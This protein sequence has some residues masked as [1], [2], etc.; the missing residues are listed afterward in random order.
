MSENSLS[1]LAGSTGYRRKSFEEAWSHAVIGATSG[2]LFTI[3]VSAVYGTYVLTAPY[4]AGIWSAIILSIVLRPNYHIANRS[5]C[6][7]KMVHLN[8]EFVHRGL[9]W[10]VLA[11]WWGLKHFFALCLRELAMFL[12]L[13]KF[14]LLA[15]FPW[16]M[17]TTTVGIVVGLCVITLGFLPFLIVHGSVIIFCLVQVTYLEESAFVDRCGS[18][19]KFL[20]VVYSVVCLAYSFTLD[21]VTITN[22]VRDVGGAASQTVK[23]GNLVN[24]LTNTLKERVLT[25]IALSFNASNV[26]KTSEEV[27]QIIQPL[28]ANLSWSNYTHYVNRLVETLDMDAADVDSMSHLSTKAAYT[29]MPIINFVFDLLMLFLSN[30]IHFFDKIYEL[31][32]FVLLYRYLSR[33]R[34]TVVYY[35]LARL[36]AAMSFDGDVSLAKARAKEIEVAVVI[37]FHSLFMSFWHKIWFHFLL[38]FFSFTYWRLPVPFLNGVAAALLGL[39]PILPTQLKWVSPCGIAFVITAIVRREVLTPD[40]LTLAVCVV[41]MYL[42]DSLMEIVLE[43]NDGLANGVNTRKRAEHERSNFILGTSIALGIV[44]YGFRGIVLGPL[45]AIFARTLFR[46]WGPVVASTIRTSQV[47]NLGMTPQ[48]PAAGLFSEP[49]QR[50]SEKNRRASSSTVSRSV[51]FE[52]RL[53]EM[54]LTVD[55]EG[56]SPQLLSDSG[57]QPLDDTFGEMPSA[58]PSTPQFVES[59]LVDTTSGEQ[60]EEGTATLPASPKEQKKRRRNKITKE[61]KNNH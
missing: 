37:P 19:W 49:S 35:C 23:E 17:H 50:G 8:E 53:A 58:L 54:Q 5:E 57:Y 56:P 9:G 39:V 15:H 61:S 18:L 25:E 51:S 47:Y 14:S 52:E 26:T 33:M 6:V 10:R 60:K 22:K 4:A 46:N 34:H 1:R 38:T 29:F 13:Q 36:L 32:L 16:L 59:A 2:L 30:I 12:G 11:S 3:V 41:M 28:I 55:D 40:Q 24:L 43:T 44:A 42:D 31:I 27:Q 7:S 45:T 48:T 21:V 20:L